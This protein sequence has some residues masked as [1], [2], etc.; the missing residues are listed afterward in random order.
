MIIMRKKS[1]STLKYNKKIQI[2]KK[3][4]KIKTNESALQWIKHH[5]LIHLST[6]K[7]DRNHLK[8]IKII[9]IINLDHLEILQLESNNLIFKKHKI[10]MQKF[11][12]INMGMFNSNKTINFIV[13]FFFFLIIAYLIMWK[14]FIFPLFM[15]CTLN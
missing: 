14:R 7:I 9:I 5:E 10:K 6:V 15:G 11:K 3:K 2:I 8:K 4:I 13:F 1:K 12:M